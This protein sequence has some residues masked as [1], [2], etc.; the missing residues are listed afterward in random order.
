VDK[1]EGEKKVS[2]KQ[3]YVEK[4][5]TCGGVVVEKEVTELLYGGVN[6]AML[7]VTVGVCLSCGERLYTP[8]LIRQFEDIGVK[9]EKQETAEFKPVGRSFHVVLPT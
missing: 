8:A 4:C 6:T 9:L 2:M 5:P 7:R 1:L 3:K